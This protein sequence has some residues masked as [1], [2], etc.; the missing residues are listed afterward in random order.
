VDLLLVT[1][2]TVA[3]SQTVARAALRAG[4]DYYDILYS[5]A[6]LSVLRSLA[7]EIRRAG[8]CFIT[9]GGLQPGLPAVLVRRAAEELDELHTAVVGSV[10]QQD[11]RAADPAPGN[12]AELLDMMA[13]ADTSICQAG[14]WRGLR[15]RDYGVRR[16]LD[17]GAPLGMRSCFAMALDEMRAL[18]RH[19]PTLRSAAFFVGGFNALV[20]WG[21]FPLAM[22]GQRF[23]LPRSRPWLTRLLGASLRRGSQPPFRTVLKLEATGLRAGA[24][25]RLQMEVGHED[26]YYLTA[27][28]VLAGIRQLI[29]GSMRRAGV[30][31]Q[32]H[33]VAPGR[34]LT[35]LAG[36]GVDVARAWPD[37]AAAGA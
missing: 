35:D 13:D 11:W 32:G 9:D 17:S 23:A 14:E 8:L 4:A 26:G 29:D 15:L 22:L 6:K 34:M 2:S 27:A 30:A 7:P 31:L 16:W 3:Y 33:A 21:L 28:C 19:Y 12:M 5:P 18:P 37:P 20:D 10:V 1:A 36:A 24:P 25:A